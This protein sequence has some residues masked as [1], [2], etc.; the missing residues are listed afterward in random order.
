MGGLNAASYMDK[1]VMIC[2]ATNVFF[3][4]ASMLGLMTSRFWFHVLN[5]FALVLY[6]APSMMKT[7]SPLEEL[8]AK[9]FLW[10]IMT[11]IV[12]CCLLCSEPRLWELITY[13]AGVPTASFLISFVRV[14]VE[15][16]EGYVCTALSPVYMFSPSLFLAALRMWD[17]PEYSNYILGFAMFSPFLF[18]GSMMVNHLKSELLAARAELQKEVHRLAD[19]TKEL[20]AMNSQLVGTQNALR[21]IL[22]ALCDNVATLDSSLRIMQPSGQLCELL[23][24][25]CGTT[26]DNVSGRKFLDFIAAEEEVPQV[27]KWL[28]STESLSSCGSRVASAFNMW[29]KDT[30]ERRFRVEAFHAS[31]VSGGEASVVTHLVGLRMHPETTLPSSSQSSGAGQCSGAGNTADAVSSDRTEASTLQR[32]QRLNGRRSGDRSIVAIRFDAGDD[33]LCLLGESFLDAF[34]RPSRSCPGLLHW[35]SR[36]DGVRFVES[37]SRHVQYAPWNRVTEIPLGHQVVLQIPRGAGYITADMAVLEMEPLTNERDHDIPVTLWLRGLTVV[38]RH[39]LESHTQESLCRL[40]E[41]E[42]TDW[43]SMS[44]FSN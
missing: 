7:C 40:D 8:N 5:V 10:D 36:A 28:N 6:F 26:Y 13:G 15:I 12:P 18:S 14:F 20:N 19:A 41:D 43:G 9:L 39:D 29:M 21:S 24:P 44:V 33:S 1:V 16:N 31:F 35:M 38:Y 42:I 23:Q 27:D 4:G 22:T 37:V 25:D 11:I 17:A 30:K 2:I 34:L 3:V 32:P